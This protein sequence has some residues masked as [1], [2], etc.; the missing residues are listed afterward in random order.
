VVYSCR[1][2]V[3]VQGEDGSVMVLFSRRVIYIKLYIAV[4]WSLC[5][6]LGLYIFLG[7]ET[8]PATIILPD[9]WLFSLF[10]LFAG[11]VR[12]LC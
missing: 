2:I 1:G 3:P 6:S 5:D 4:S 9:P 11:S 10:L 12:V 8:S 7:E